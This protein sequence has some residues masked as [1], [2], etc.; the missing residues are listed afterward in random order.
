VRILTTSFVLA[1]LL[2]ALAGAAAF[3]TISTGETVADA[4][5]VILDHLNG[6][7]VGEARGGLGYVAGVSGLGSAGD[8]ATGKD[9]V[10]PVAPN[11]EAQGT[12][13]LWI[14]PRVY[15]NELVNFNWGLNTSRPPSG[16]VISLRLTAEG[17][18]YL[19]GWSHSSASC[20]FTPLTGATTV[21]LNAW[22]HIAVTWA[23]ETRIYV[24]GSV[25][26]LSPVCFSPAVDGD[27]WVYLNPWGGWDL[28]YADE[29]HVSR[30]ARSAE[31]IASRVEPPEAVPGL[32]AF[33]LGAAAA[34]LLAVQLLV[35]R[36]RRRRS[37]STN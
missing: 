14:K 31:V 32:S 35:G 12:T 27:G 26:A 21:P 25:D 23:S 3:A 9:V 29:F 37:A 11:L 34:A 2:E 28:G 4:D 1:D 7:S 30:I 36:S 33:G 10:Y 13:E 24:N 15:G 20:G 16:H 5:T 6:A 17:K 18:V 19:K 22:T 8:F